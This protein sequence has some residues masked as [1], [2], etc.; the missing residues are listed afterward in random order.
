MENLQ[1]DQFVEDGPAPEQDDR[2]EPCQTTLHHDA[3]ACIAARLRSCGPYFTMATAPSGLASRWTTWP[4]RRR[5]QIL[6]FG[7]L[8]QP[9]R[10]EQG[11]FLQLQAAPLVQQTPLFRAQRFQLVAGDA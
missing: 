9:L 10:A 4:G 2:G 5:H 1:R 3:T 11:G 6:P 8:L 7:E